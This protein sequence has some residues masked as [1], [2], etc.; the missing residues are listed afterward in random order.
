MLKVQRRKRP[1][2]ILHICQQQVNPGF[3]PQSSAAGGPGGL[4]AAAAL[5]C[6]PWG[7]ICGRRGH[8]TDWCI[9][10]M[11]Y[12]LY[13]TKIQLKT[14]CSLN[15]SIWQILVMSGQ[16]EQAYKMLLFRVFDINIY[17]YMSNIPVWWLA[18]RR[19][20]SRASHQHSCPRG[21]INVCSSSSCCCR[22]LPAA[23]AS[24]PASS[25]PPS[26][27]MVRIPHLKEKCQRISVRVIQ[28]DHLWVC[29]KYFKLW[30]RAAYVSN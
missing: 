14:V 5:A 30:R 26:T 23:P 22:R 6:R 25:S 15:Q 3:S 27:P 12:I 1:L 11:R 10:K 29:H 4:A 8:F 16:Q 9:Q 17:K 7:W 13:W 21:N 18:G 19:K 2:C 20:G 28:K 24:S